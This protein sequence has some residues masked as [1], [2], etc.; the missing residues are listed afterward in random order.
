MEKDEKLERLPRYSDTPTPHKK[1][2]GN[3]TEFGYFGAY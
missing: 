3:R 1:S 2:D